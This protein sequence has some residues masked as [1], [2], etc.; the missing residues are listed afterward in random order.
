MV[1]DASHVVLGGSGHIASAPAEAVLRST[2]HVGIVTC[3]ASKAAEWSARGAG[4][5]VVDLEDQA[6]MAHV[7]SSS[8]P[9][10]AFALDRPG[11]IS[12]DPC[13]AVAGP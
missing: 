10:R 4:P 9:V 6:A 5:A 3:S 8:S 12:S 11:S 13:A 7:P 1:D 2:R